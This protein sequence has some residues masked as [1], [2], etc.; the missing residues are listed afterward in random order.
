MGRLLHLLPSAVFVVCV[1]PTAFV[2]GLVIA[3]V[4]RDYLGRGAVSIAFTG[5]VAWGW[6]QWSPRAGE[7]PLW[8]VLLA[9][10]AGWVCPLLVSQGSQTNPSPNRD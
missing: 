6:A 1:L 7:W 8:S 4:I 5:Y 2:G 10:S 9:W 3:T